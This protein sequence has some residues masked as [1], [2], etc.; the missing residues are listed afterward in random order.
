MSSRSDR[1]F[2]PGPREE[3]SA[4]AS[5]TTPSQSRISPSMRQTQTIHTAA[6]RICR[7]NELLA[8]GQPI[9]ALNSYTE[10]L[11]N[12]EAGR[13]HPVAFINRSLCYLILRYPEL[14]AADAYRAI[15][16]VEWALEDGQSCTQHQQLIVFSQVARDEQLRRPPFEQKWTKKPTC[17]VGEGKIKDLA[18][19]LASIMVG[20]RGWEYHNV[21]K[22]RGGKEFIVKK[23]K[24]NVFE[25]VLLK[26][27]YRLIL[28]LMMCGG[29]ALQ[30]AIGYIDH[31]DGEY[32]IK[33]DDED[34][35]N[36][37]GE[38]LLQHI[39]DE[40]GWE[41]RKQTS[42]I[43]SGDKE[44][45][46]EIDRL[47]AERGLSALLKTCFTKIPRQLYPWDN[48]SVTNSNVSERIT[49]LDRTVAESAR[50]CKLKAVVSI[51]HPPKLFLAARNDI[52]SA[53][54]FLTESFVLTATTYVQSTVGADT[55]YYCDNC[56]AE[57]E[58]SRAVFDA[59][60]ENAE[61]GSS[62]NSE[63]SAMVGVKAEEDTTEISHQR[64]EVSAG[65]TSIKFVKPK[66]P[67]YSAK[68]Y[69]FGSARD[70]KNSKKEYP[71][72]PK[73]SRSISTDERSIPADSDSDSSSEGFG[74]GF[75]I[76][77]DCKMVVFCDDYCKT[78]ALNGTHVSFC[79]MEIDKYAESA[80]PHRY[81][82]VPSTQKQVLLRKALVKAYS[83]MPSSGS[84]LAVT[85]IQLLDGA[86]ENPRPFENKISLKF[87]VEIPKHGILFDDTVRSAMALRRKD[88]QDVK[89]KL[90]ALISNR[91]NKVK[92]AGTG[93]TLYLDWS[94]D[95]NVRYPL[96]CLFNMGGHDLTMDTQT[97]DGWMLN[98]LIAK[99]ESAMQITEY[100]RFRKTFGS[101]GH[102]IHYSIPPED[103][104]YGATCNP[105]GKMK[106][107]SNPFST[108]PGPVWV[109]S[110]HP[111]TSLLQPAGKGDQPNVF[112][113]EIGEFLV[114]SGSEDNLSSDSNS[115]AR[116][117]GTP[118]IRLGD[119]LI[120]DATIQRKT[121]KQPKIV[122]SVEEDTE[123]QAPAEAILSSFM[124]EVDETEFSD[125]PMMLD[126]PET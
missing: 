25:D 55:F 82:G 92:R 75:Q 22:H 64:N 116:E 27:Y 52:V 41:N 84:I 26:A 39:E 32:D 14:A 10:T 17:Y 94:F 58:A 109:G 96:Y 45:A 83:E 76:C 121:P 21:I 88:Q 115:L 123:E 57:L 47:I 62:N 34:Q 78:T 106:S 31:V 85:W 122:P 66:S 29:G 54:P 38:K 35:F 105:K 49:A 9:D 33:P 117:T 80:L 87:N 12:S 93:Q 23:R 63:T 59:A 72:S 79:N 90:M 120:R 44:Q 3:S 6:R 4:S 56:S 16:G 15:I 7:A 111:I 125:D 40:I 46:E 36:A 53:E 107:S 95:Q 119:K 98:T 43:K 48:H 102:V 74:M 18:Q 118:R 24:G 51:D 70:R 91:R 2:T 126:E 65:S 61:H 5:S 101:A 1:E 77:K 112:V 68:T 89:G 71:L 108:A 69:L 50:D 86:L 113:S 110:I 8:R 99:L 30:T 100:P 19:P 67:E 60:N 124:L 81:P 28:A 37:L 97:F 20:E 11:N 114:C 13:G 42:A 104:D 103:R 73:S